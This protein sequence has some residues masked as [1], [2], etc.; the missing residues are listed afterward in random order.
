[1]LADISPSWLSIVFLLASGRDPTFYTISNYDRSASSVPLSQILDFIS[2]I[3]ED[4]VNSEGS[5]KLRMQFSA[6]ACC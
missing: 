5:L 4:F 2:I 6:T 3:D 1:M